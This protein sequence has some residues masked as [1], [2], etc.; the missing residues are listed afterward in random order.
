MAN[1]ATCIPRPDLDLFRRGLD[2]IV[3]TVM[4]KSGSAGAQ[5][6]LRYSEDV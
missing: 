6:V 4:N 1:L 5:S 2:E 3:K